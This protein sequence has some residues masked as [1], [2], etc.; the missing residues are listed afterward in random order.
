MYVRRETLVVAMALLGIAAICACN[1]GGGDSGSVFSIVSA[2]VETELCIRDSL[3]PPVELRGEI[4]ADDCDDPDAGFSEAYRAGIN[5]EEAIEGS[6]SLFGFPSLVG[7]L[8]LYR[9]DDPSD[10][11]NS[12]VLLDSD[13]F[14]I[15][16]LLEPGTE[17][18]IVITGDDDTELGE[19]ELIFD[20]DFHFDDD[21]REPDDG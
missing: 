16:H 14:L 11:V 13:P 10:Y 1:G 8:T 6:F 19:Y 4:E 15:N 7:F 2:D 17:Y 21:F 18:L 5:A 3:I 12:L 9:V 20:D